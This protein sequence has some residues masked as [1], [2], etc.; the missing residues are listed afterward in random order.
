VQIFPSAAT[1]KNIIPFSEG[2]ELKMHEQLLKR[3]KM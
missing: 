2:N 3:L 1:G